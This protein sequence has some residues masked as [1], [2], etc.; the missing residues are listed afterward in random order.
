MI[1]WLLLLTLACACNQ[2]HGLDQTGLIYDTPPIDAPWACP[3]IGTMPTFSR[4]LHQLP[5]RGCRQ[6]TFSPKTKR[7][8]ALC[9]PNG[10]GANKESFVG[11]GP[12]DDELTPALS[13]PE[14]FENPRLTPDGQRLYVSHQQG[15]TVVTEQY[16]RV[17]DTW[18][19]TKTNPFPNGYISTIATGPGGDRAL[20]Y[21]GGGLWE[22]WAE[23]A[24]T[25]MVVGPFD[26]D[27]PLIAPVHTSLSLDGLR[28]IFEG[29]DYNDGRVSMYYSDRSAVDQRFRTPVVIDVPK[30]QD[31][32]AMTE[33]CGKLYVFGLERLFYV[34]Q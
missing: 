11:E 18:V 14:P 16:T 15:T 28:V 2:V 1:R 31:L 4:Q 8:V 3:A 23:I 22:E 19:L 20:M 7:A 17:N 29:L 5:G 9:Y 25:W 21:T 26:A 34:S 30:S 13:S 6:Y 32:V 10:V 24:G 12:L 27:F 33:D